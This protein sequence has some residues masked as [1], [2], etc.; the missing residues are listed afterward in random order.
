M[1]AGFA[2]VI[3]GSAL[4]TTCV[5]PAEVLPVKFVSPSYIAVIVCDPALRAEVLRVATP[6]FRAPVPSEL[7]PSLKVTEPVGVPLFDDTVAVNVT[8]CPYVLG[9]SEDAITVEEFACPTVWLNAGAVLL[10][11]PVALK[12]LSPL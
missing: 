2:H 3:L 7:E 4:L 6:A 5:M 10:P 1:S 11:A 12:L 8:A 9:V